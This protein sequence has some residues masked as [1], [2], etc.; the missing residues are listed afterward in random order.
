MIVLQQ[1]SSETKTKAECHWNTYW[2]CSQALRSLEHIHS[3]TSSL[4]PHKCHY[5]NYKEKSLYTLKKTATDK[6]NLEF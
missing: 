1:D 2:S 4:H 5:Y 3:G 6:K